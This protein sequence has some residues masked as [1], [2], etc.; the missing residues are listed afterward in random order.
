VSTNPYAGN[1]LGFNTFL[2]EF[3]DISPAATVPEWDRLSTFVLTTDMRVDTTH[4]FL[5]TRRCHMTQR[6]RTSLLALQDCRMTGYSQ[7]TA[8]PVRSDGANDVLQESG[9]LL[10]DTMVA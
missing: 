4:Q 1:V 5:S 2:D 7:A 3:V 6:S 10:R 8:S 9:G